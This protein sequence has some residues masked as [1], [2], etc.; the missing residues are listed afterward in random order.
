M[1]IVIRQSAKTLIVTYLGFLIGYVNTLIFYPL[2]LSVEQ[3]GLQRILLD[4]TG[5]FATFAAL[6]AT[7]IPVRYFP[8]F[9]D[10]KKEHNGFLFFLF[11]L[12]FVGYIVFVALFFIFKDTLIG[13][14]SR[15]AAQ[16]TEYF[17]YLIP[18][19]FIQLCLFILE[20][21]MLVQLKPVVPRFIREIV[22]RVLLTL[23]VLGILY[24]MITFH[25]FINF[26]FVVYVIALLLL[27]IYVYSRGVLFLRPNFSVFKNPMLKSML[28]FGGFVLLGNT[29]DIIIR[30]ID[31]LMLG[32][33]SGL[34]STGIYTIALYIALVL[35]I[36]RRSMSQ[37]VIPLV[38]EATKNGDMKKIAEIYKKSSIN[39]M[40]IGGLV[41]L[42][43]WCNIDNIFKFIP[44]G[45]VFIAGKYVVFYLGIGKLFDM[46]MGIN[47]EIMTTSKYYKYDIFFY[48]GLSLLAIGTNMLLIPIW[49]I[50]GAAMASAIS[51]IIYNLVRFAFIW[52]IYRMQPFSKQTVKVLLISLVVLI[53][54]YM[55]PHVS[56]HFVWDVAIR[57][58]F[59][60]VLFSLLVLLSRASE[61]INAVL[62][63][64]I[65]RF[66][67][68][69][70]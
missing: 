25:V 12:S 70:Q 55:F 32:S 21:Y 22:I 49:G 45:S 48:A 64:T 26:I 44:N 17:Y 15:N 63:R 23:G 4:V 28:V 66:L 40:I 27:V 57:G 19:T 13:I 24:H 62:S 42:V 16:L 8:Y 58:F 29:S 31:S 20:V 61:D 2:A 43:I 67:E 52:R 10:P 51:I 38:A 36:P 1:G 59:I 11:C 3:I 41:F 37:V 39:Q 65:R 54:N 56:G 14:Y 35:E 60:A 6:G 18:F 34:K 33:Y 47:A 5:F 53:F 46:A 9:K 50:L 7:H 68:K 69:V 30:N